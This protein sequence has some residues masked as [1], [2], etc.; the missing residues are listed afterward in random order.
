MTQK[1]NYALSLETVKEWINKGRII[2]KTVNTLAEDLKDYLITRT[3]LIY[4]TFTFTILKFKAAICFGQHLP[5]L[6]RHYTNTV[7]VGVAYCYRCRLFTVY[8]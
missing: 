2:N 3:N 4:F 7:L 6:R 8:G 5:I 1:I